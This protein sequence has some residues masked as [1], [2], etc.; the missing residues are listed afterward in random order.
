MEYSERMEQALEE[1]C[2]HCNLGTGPACDKVG[3]LA[4]FGKIPAIK[5]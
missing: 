5:I 3:C 1:L 4:W 2:H